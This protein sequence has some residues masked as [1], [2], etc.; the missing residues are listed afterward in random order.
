[1]Q[2]LAI[3]VKSRML[4]TAASL[5]ELTHLPHFPSH[6]VFDHVPSTMAS[7]G[8]TSLQKGYKKRHQCG[9]TPVKHRSLCL[10]LLLGKKWWA[11]VDKH[12][13]NKEQTSKNSLKTG[14]K[15]GQWSKVAIRAK[16]LI[17]GLKIKMACDAAESHWGAQITS[18]S[19]WFPL[20]PPKETFV[21][22]ASPAELLKC[23]NERE[24]MK[25]KL[26]K[27]ELDYTNFVT[28]TGSVHIPAPPVYFDAN[29]RKRFIPDIQKYC[30][31]Y[32]IKL[33]Q[34]R[35]VSTK[36]RSVTQY[37]LHG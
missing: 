22:A 33:L 23:R 2:V 9:E 6:Q 28:K 17:C 19:T 4:A 10:N 8:P 26:I 5:N 13:F 36:L 16:W 34:T 24:V 1:M 31:F 20:I 25:T 27:Y 12:K 30:I 32:G 35:E 7:Q 11:A 15:R 14:L 37:P 3:A 18:C 21:V 29:S